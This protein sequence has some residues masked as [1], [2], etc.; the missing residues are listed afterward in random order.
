MLEERQ[1]DSNPGKR[2]A[3]LDGLR[4]LAAFIVVIHHCVATYF[5]MPFPNWIRYS[6]LRLLTDGRAAVLVFFV[7]SGF[8]LYLSLQKGCESRRYWPYITKRFLRLYPPFIVA[9]FVS[10]VLWLIVEPKSILGIPAWF[11][12]GNWETRPN[13]S[14]VMAHLAMTNNK[15]WQSLDV[16]MWSLVHEARIS[17]IFPIIAACVAKNWMLTLIVG[18]IASE[19]SRQ[20]ASGPTNDLWFNPV[21]TAQ[22][23]VLF[24]GGAVLAQNASHIKFRFASLSMIQRALLVF[25]SLTALIS[26]ISSSSYSILAQIGAA[27]VVTVSFADRNAVQ[28]LSSEVPAFLGKISYSLYLIHL[29]ILFTLVH[30]L[31]GHVPLLGILAIVV[32]ISIF[33]AYVMYRCIEV[34][35]IKLGRLLAK[36]LAARISSSDLQL[37][38]VATKM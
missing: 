4:G 33:L 22:F 23:L 26:S 24:V 6:P 27:C 20:F 9:I 17:I 25:V 3:S 29:P 38:H 8:V 16:V 11:N 31:W 34:P 19:L 32:P 36:G 18:G 35:A 10:A 37:E 12:S 14:L 30:V 15:Q 21:D 2:Y 7:L 13:L 28:F 1:S 5:G